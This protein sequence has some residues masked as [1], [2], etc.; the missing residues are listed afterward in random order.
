MNSMSNFDV[1][2]LWA[3]FIGNLAFIAVLI[4]ILRME[5]MTKIF[6]GQWHHFYR[7]LVPIVII[8]IAKDGI[9]AP[10]LHFFPT[11][12]YLIEGVC[13]IAFPWAIAFLFYCAVLG[14]Y[15]RLKLLIGTPEQSVLSEFVK[16]TDSICGPVQR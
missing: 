8:M 12:H 2:I 14:Q 3:S 11:W 9:C 15:R 13:L 7:W 16:F 5:K 10:L 6:G 1:S 4:F